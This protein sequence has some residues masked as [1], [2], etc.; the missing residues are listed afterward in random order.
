MY[1]IKEKRTI[2]EKGRKRPHQQQQ[3]G[4]VAGHQ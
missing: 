2:H 1:E 3:L 4:V